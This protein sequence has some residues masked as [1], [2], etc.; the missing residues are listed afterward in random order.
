MIAVDSQELLDIIQDLRAQLNALT[1]RVE[2]VES[3]AP[4]VLSVVGQALPPANSASEGAPS[5]IAPV[6]EAPLA[7]TEEELLAISAAIA[8]FLG[9]RAHIRQIR[10]I[11]S[12]MWAQ[13]GRATIQASHR[14]HS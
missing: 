11:S 1:Q 4:A 9:V 5:A 13:E 6:A 8:A 7:I 12:N 14:L 2:H 3:A 10:L